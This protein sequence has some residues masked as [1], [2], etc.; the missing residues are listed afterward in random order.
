MNYSMEYT[1]MGLD[2]KE[3]MKMKITH[4]LNNSITKNKIA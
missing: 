2:Y 3:N 4:T 1:S